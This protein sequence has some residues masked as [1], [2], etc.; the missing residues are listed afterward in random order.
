MHAK[1]LCSRVEVAGSAGAADRG[2]LQ[3]RLAIR[4][5]ALRNRRRRQGGAVGHAAVRALHHSSR[6]GLERHRSKCFVHLTLRDGV[7]VAV[8]GPTDESG[9]QHT[10]GLEE[11]GEGPCWAAV[12]RAGGE[13]GQRD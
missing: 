4:R 6:R 3:Q 5:L 8:D 1:R 13:Q 12:R 9:V 7:A 11:G 10:A 2:H